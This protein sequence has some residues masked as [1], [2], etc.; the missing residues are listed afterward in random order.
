VTAG[1]AMLHY[2]EQHPEVYDALEERAAQLT[3]YVPEGVCVNRVGSMFTFF[4]QPGPV[5]DFESAKRS[6]TARFGRFFHFLLDHGVYFPPSQF[7]AG[8]LS[9]AHTDRDIAKT[10]STIR[11]FFESE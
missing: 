6:D 4:F 11:E 5:T 10:M 8:F 2:L 3:S 9:A 1:I 7:E